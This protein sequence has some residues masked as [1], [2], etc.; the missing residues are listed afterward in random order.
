MDEQPPHVTIVVSRIDHT[1]PMQLCLDLATDLEAAGHQ[2]TILEIK[3]FLKLGWIGQL[4]AALRTTGERD[5][6]LSCGALSDIATALLRL[7]GQRGQR[8]F[9][10]Y[11]HCDQWQDLRFE[12]SLLWTIAYYAFWRS[13][14]YLKDRISCVSFDLVNNLPKRLAARSTVIY[15]HVS[16]ISVDEHGT[17]GDEDLAPALGWIA[18]QRTRGRRVVLAFGLF[19][20]R[21]NF[22]ALIRAIESL[23]G[24]S[25]LLVGRGPE[26]ATLK[27]AACGMETDGRVL[28]HPFLPQPA[29]LCAFVD[30]Y[31]SCSQ[32]EGFGLANVEAARSGTPTIVPCHAVNLEVLSG[33]SNVTFYNP[34]ASH[35]LSE[36]VKGIVAPSAQRHAPPQSGERYSR[37]S[38]SSDWVRFVAITNGI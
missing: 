13:S 14:L 5:I 10:S 7:L 25:L 33:F 8:K 20:R 29:R 34:Y 9:V 4:L 15:N 16:A 3:Q 36:T 12:R 23:G 35:H 26:E 1:S 21:K 32:S 6:L 38:F 30:V 31:V 24:V 22:D 11:L 18:E 27:N 19:L 2:V 17:T 28:I 37:E